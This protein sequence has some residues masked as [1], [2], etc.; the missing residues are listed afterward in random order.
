MTITEHLQQ[1]EPARQPLLQALNDIIL[2]NDTTVTPVIGDMMGKQMIIYNDRGSFKY[3][4]ASVKEH[5][6]L[7]VLP[8]YMNVPLHTKY[9][10]LLPQAKFQK[11]C[12]N[13]KN[14][15]ELLLDVAAQ[16][17]SDCAGIDL[18]AI[19]EKQL[20]DRKKKK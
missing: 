4:L 3:G 16:L 18:V 19:R 1:Q 13:F 8:M 6:S 10:T 12:I 5:M 7:H 11:G 15:D 17:I 20:A 9:E 2:A 14:E